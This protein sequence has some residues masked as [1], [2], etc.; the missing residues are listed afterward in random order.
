MQLAYIYFPRNFFSNKNTYF[1]SRKLGHLP[2]YVLRTFIC[3]IFFSEEDTLA[4]FSKNFIPRKNDKRQAFH[5]QDSSGVFII[6][7]TYFLY[8]ENIQNNQSLTACLNTFSLP[9]KSI[10]EPFFYC[11]HSNTFSTKKS[12][13]TF[14]RVL[15]ES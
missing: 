2:C 5:T 15:Q 7:T 12:Y 14:I 9:R 13:K 6:G 11:M 1:N 10:K 8:Q 3:L 4:I